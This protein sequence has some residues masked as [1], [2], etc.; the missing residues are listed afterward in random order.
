MAMSAAIRKVL[1]PISE[2]MIIDKERRKEWRGCIREA[3]AEVSN[4]LDGVKDFMISLIWS[5]SFLE[6][7]GGTGWGISWGF[8]GRSAGFYN[9][10]I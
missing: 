1:S 3:G 8:S 2:N 4:V 5:G 10:S 9:R 7:V 6:V